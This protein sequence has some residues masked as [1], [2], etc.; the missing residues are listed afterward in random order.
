VFVQS[1]TALPLPYDR[2][3]LSRA[4]EDWSSAA[5]Q[6]DDASLAE[7]ML[8]APS[9]PALTRLL[10]SIF[11]NSPY[12]TSLSL[13]HPAILMSAWNMGLEATWAGIMG[14]LAT[15]VSDIAPD[16]HGSLMAH[17][18]RIK[19]RAALLIAVADIAGAW[20]LERVTGALSDL[21][22][23]CVQAAL[24]ALLREAAAKGDFTLSEPAQ[25]E[26][27]CGYVVFALGKHGGREL[28]YSSDIDLLVLFDDAAM[29]YVGK[30]SRQEFA[31]K[32]TRDLVKI[33]QER[34]ADGYVFR[35][36]L[37][38]RPDPGSTA[39]AVARSAAA[40]YYESYG[41]NWERAAMIKARAIAGDALTAAG[42]LKDLETFI[43]R[44][45]LDFYA[46]QDIHSIKR[47]IYAHKGGGTVTVPGH[48][49][50]LGRGGIREIEF[51][52]QTQ[53][54]IWG[55]RKPEARSTQTIQALEALTHM[56]VVTPP[57]RDDLARCYEYLRRLEHRLQMIN[58]EQTQKLPADAQGIAHIAAFMGD[59]S[60]D[61]FS[62]S[63]M[64]ILRT[65]ETH[66]AALFE[67]S[68]A[69]GIEGNLVFTGTEDD[70]DT[71][72]TLRKLGFQNP[73]MVIAAVRIWHTGRAKATKSLRAR[74]LLTEL[75]P[76]LLQAFGRTAEP[77]G[78]F[79]RFDHCMNQINSGVQLLS[80]FYSN[81]SLL[82]FIA[83]VMGD[84]PQLAENITRNPA[85]LDY[86]LDPGFFRPLPP[87]SDLQAEAARVTGT[88]MHLDV[89]IDACKQ[90]TNEHR[91]QIGAQMLRGLMDPIAASRAITNIAEAGLTALIPRLHNEFA[92][93]YGRV[94]NS[95]MGII[96]YGKLGSRELTPASDLDLV[97]VY[98][99]SEDAMS[100]G[101]EK[102]F[103]ASAY[104]IR[105]TQRIISA[106]T[107]MTQQGRMF[108]V[109][110][111][112]RPNG[113][114]GPLAC[115]TEAFI[116]YQ[117]H[118]AWTWEHL[119]LTRTRVIL[120]GPQVRAEIEAGIQGGLTKPRD[121]DAALVAIAN[122]RTK[123][124]QA[125]ESSGA[126]NIKRMPGG[127]I[128]IE[129]LVLS[130]LLRYPAACSAENPGIGAAI[131]RLAA[132]GTLSP[133]NAQTL[134]EAFDLW[135]R[136][137]VMLRLTLPD[138]VAK[139]PF[140]AG[141]ATKLAKTANLPDMTALER[142]IATT[143]AA[144]AEI[145]ESMIDRPAKKARIK[146]G[147]TI[148]H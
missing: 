51:F 13:R 116:K 95:E 17:L 56:G 46:L 38:L 35:T 144:V 100:A 88:G 18:R 29:P 125:Q 39:I 67:D 80:V 22:D 10:A 139:P 132:H 28:N 94:P 15:G 103:P 19:G 61:A 57:I 77:D 130:L 64:G 115:S 75:M 68:P 54:L 122:M 101:G 138:D 113:D 89:A 16:N 102:S 93:Q 143:A 65:V 36:D 44:R 60:A 42:F 8:A 26:H 97:V 12:L 24:Q 34:T 142:N 83:D 129:F 9:Q 11:G 118:D 27:N 62:A 20:P 104:Y 105:L 91:F 120:G 49:I 73:S 86:V 121:P 7:F 63:V 117:A 107:S 147:D 59:D 79:T 124:R 74:Q 52:A 33:M 70:P 45:S 106:L 2:G 148:P 128:D 141:L 41:Q 4:L 47:Q 123:M 78:A 58:D 5:R 53:Q 136:L 72:E 137:M 69:L 114:K 110:L 109:D 108:D 81:P 92:A 119:A 111:R 25:P 145:Y 14:D 23:G 85:L 134:S 37:R 43:W 146:F 3:A 135:S 87:F 50:K 1:T 31:V 66:Y 126:W 99:G 98:T 48:N 90:W 140:P 76:R 30:R 96:A 84:A 71:L 112:L 40:I 82:D 6:V 131:N 32:L 127:L 133:V 55:G 21:A